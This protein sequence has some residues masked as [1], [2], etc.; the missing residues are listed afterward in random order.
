MR[1]LYIC[2]WE[3]LTGGAALACWN[4]VLDMKA[5]YKIEP[6]ILVK[7]EGTVAEECRRN[8]IEVVVMPHYWWYCGENFK[9]KIKS[10]VKN[11]FN[12]F[13]Y[14]RILKYFADK[15]FNLVHSNSSVTDIGDVIAQ[16]LNIPHVWHLREY[17]LK[18]YGL[19]FVKNKKIVTA[20]FNR[21]NK[22][23]A[24]SRD[25][26][27]YYAK[28]M[29]LCDEE[30][31]KIIYNGIKINTEYH[32]KYNLKI[33]FCMAGM[34]CNGKNQIMALRAC[35]ILR[36]RN[37]NFILNFIGEG[38]DEALL[39]NFVHENNLNDCVKFWGFRSDI[40][41][42]LKNMDVGLMLS[43]SE[44]FGRVTVEYMLNYMPVIGVNT[45]A[46]P[47][48]ISDGTG[49]ICDLDDAQRLSDIMYYEFIKQPEKIISMG[50]NARDHAVKNFPLE[51]NTDEIYEIY[52]EV[53]NGK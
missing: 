35:K 19:H 10:K 22:L 18:D 1:V 3:N 34:L 42:I 40:Q 49:F 5:R 32:K 31:I 9:D 21:A 39:K 45:G 4:M 17:G 33:N 23:I 16:K 29:R 44:A 14:A 20:K 48:I 46:T 30:N 28:Y 24:I 41:E 27:D 43:K 8:N 6:C 13:Y 53:L 38:G 26:Y 7:G 15:K 36:E 25:V 52:Q 37:N 51:K 12:K 2:H 50:Q 11:I 47:E